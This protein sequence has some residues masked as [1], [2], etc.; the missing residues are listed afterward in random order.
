M[1][2]HKE[3]KMLSVTD[4]T[5]SDIYRKNPTDNVQDGDACK[6]HQWEGHE[7][8]CEHGGAF[9]G[10][11]D[12]HAAAACKSGHP[13]EGGKRPTE[14]CIELGPLRGLQ[15]R[16]KRQIIPWEMMLG[17]TEDSRA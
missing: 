9:G 7:R 10:E 2:G 13:S 15:T 8:S 17:Y 6:G 11:T 14:I 3:V 12:S 16:G 1:A 5:V 4:Q